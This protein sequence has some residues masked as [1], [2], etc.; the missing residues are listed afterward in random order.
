MHPLQPLYD[1]IYTRG[2]EEL[3][4]YDE[5]G[6]LMLCV[7]CRKEVR[8]GCVLVT[9]ILCIT[10]RP[11]YDAL[12]EILGPEGFL[13]SYANDVYTG[14]VPT[15]VA[16]ALSVAS[17]LYAMD[18]LQL[19]WGPKK[20]KLVLPSGCDLDSLPLPR[21]PEGRSLQDIVIGFKACLSIPGHP[22][23]E[24]SCIV[25]AL[26][27]VVKRHDSLVDLAVV[28]S[29]ED[30]FVALR[31]LQVCGVINNYLAHFIR[32]NSHTRNST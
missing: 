27:P 11:V 16:L 8:Q 26:E 28:V 29:K 22:K 31:L 10:V 9:T 32:V 15:K 23:N 25:A 13:F 6:N 2:R 20:T 14:G 3:W 21:D 18:G 19:G 30:P 17:D 4:Y 5:V 7:L 24:D 12:L 1:V